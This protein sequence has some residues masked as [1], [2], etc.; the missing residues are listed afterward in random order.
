MKSLFICV[1]KSKYS[2]HELKNTNASFGFF[3]KKTLNDV[4][5]IRSNRVYSQILWKNCLKNATQLAIYCKGFWLHMAVCIYE[6][7][8]T[9]HHIV[10]VLYIFWQ[11]S[12]ESD[13]V[14]GFP[15]YIHTAR[16]VALMHSHHSLVTRSCW[17]TLVKA[18]LFQQIV[19]WFPQ[20]NEYNI[21]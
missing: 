1:P 4:S 18:G 3:K 17:Q 6:C 5:N 7:V 15:N 14:A 13:N 11:I 21:K 2:L 16:N 12:R 20:S 8:A 19:Q 10:K 9:K